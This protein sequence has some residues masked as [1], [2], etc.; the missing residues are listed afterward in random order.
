MTEDRETIVARARSLQRAQRGMMEGLVDLRQEHGLTQ[1]EVASRMGVSQSA[2]AQFERY[3]SNPTLA[4]IQ[5]YALA[6]EAKLGL[7]VESDRA[8]DH[9]AA[10]DF[11]AE[12]SAPMQ[13]EYAGAIGDQTI[14]WGQKRSVY[15]EAR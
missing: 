14:N 11:V 10:H 12:T 8:H 13:V 6:V 2:V 5:K 1:A 9:F 4:T 7:R 3:D 15:V